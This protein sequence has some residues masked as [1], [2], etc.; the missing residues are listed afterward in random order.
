MLEDEKRRELWIAEIESLRKR[1]SDTHVAFRN[2]SGNFSQLAIRS[3]M[4]INGGAMFAGLAFIGALTSA[5]AESNYWAGFIAA[6]VCFAGGIAFAAACTL[7]AYLNYESHALRELS[8]TEVEVIRISKSY[9]PDFYSDQT[10]AIEDNTAFW[11]EE[12]EKH[13]KI[14]VTSQKFGLGFAIVSYVLFI[15]GCTVVGVTM[16]TA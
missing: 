13:E 15:V 1:G 7:A 9:Y 6:W 11:S 10:K 2:L 8:N 16:A 4:V 5:D 12:I 3:A 14:I